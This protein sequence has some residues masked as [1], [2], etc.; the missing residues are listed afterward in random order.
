MVQL[1]NP[2]KRHLRFRGHPDASM[3]WFL[4]GFFVEQ[5]GL[6]A[7]VKVEEGLQKLM[8]QTEEVCKILSASGTTAVL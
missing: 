7:P 3:L 2:P 5:F 1:G 8:S 6:G 4:L